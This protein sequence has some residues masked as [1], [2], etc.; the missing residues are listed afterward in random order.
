MVRPGST[1]LLGMAL[2]LGAPFGA[3][4]QGKAGV[5]AEFERLRALPGGETPFGRV[6]LALWAL[7]KG[8]P[9][10]AWPLV[11]P[12][13]EGGLRPPGW[14]ALEEAAC[15]EILGGEGRR[16]TFKAMGRALLSRRGKP[17]PALKHFVARALAR[18][19]EEERAQGRENSRRS[20]GAFLRHEAEKG[21][22]PWIRRAARLALLWSSPEQ[23]R[24]V[25]RMTLRYPEGPTR[26]AVLE[27]I[28]R[29]GRLERA[30]RYLGTF[31]NRTISGLELRAARVLGSLGS[32]AAL[33]ALREARAGLA[34][35]KARLVARALARAAGERGGGGGS[36]RAY[37][38]VLTQDSYV[39]DFDAQV[40]QSGVIAD[41]KVGVV[42]SGVVLDVKVLNV[43]VVRYLAFLDRT[44][45]WAIR[46]C[47][48]RPSAK[49]GKVD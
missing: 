22:K 33:P 26:K 8:L 39:K 3:S 49:P 14:K 40:A 46:R 18:L 23:E 1:F 11:D 35:T 4:S 13:V 19:L 30:A 32:P 45:R 38:A 31:L 36:P 27:E 9:E 21:L 5:E 16:S 48:S 12:V 43:E 44:L 25:Y 34:Q 7:E 6:Q 15:R 28:R 42:S 2:F 24:F 29:A 10:R 17:G 41:P 20:L 47:S 37:I